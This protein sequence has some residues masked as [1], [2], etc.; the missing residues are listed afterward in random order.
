MLW[1][2]RVPA[3]PASGAGQAAGVAGSA[4]GGAPAWCAL[5][6]PL[7]MEIWDGE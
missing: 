6:T 4:T 1:R 2:H 5:G 3:G 7:P